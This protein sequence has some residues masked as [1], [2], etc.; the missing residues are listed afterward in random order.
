MRPRWVFAHMALAC[1]QHH[2]F[3]L[4]FDQGRGW[5]LVLHQYPTPLVKTKGLAGIG[6]HE[7]IAHS[8]G[9]KQLVVLGRSAASPANMLLR[10]TLTTTTPRALPSASTTGVA[11]ITEGCSSPAWAPNSWL[12]TIG[13]R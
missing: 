13:D 7:V 10:S 9:Q 1:F 11:R 12:I 8:I 4:A 2:R 5:E 3:A 6:V